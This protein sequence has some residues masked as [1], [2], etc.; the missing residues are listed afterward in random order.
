[1]ET[2]G[3]GRPGRESSERQGR[4]RRRQVRR[5]EMG[6]RGGKCRREDTIRS[7]YLGTLTKR[8][9]ERESEGKD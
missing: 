8:K 5:G 2:G 9:V 1:M 4:E 7:R 6:A 3:E